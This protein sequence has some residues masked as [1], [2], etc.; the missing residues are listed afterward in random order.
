LF[1]A[2]CIALVT[3]AMAFSLRTDIMP[4]LGREFQLTDAMLGVAVGPGLWGFTLSIIFWGALLDVLGMR[5][6][7]WM[8]FAGHLIGTTLV[9]V[10]PG[11]WTLWTAWLVIG[12]SNGMVE[13]SINPL[14][15]TIYPD[16]KTQMLNILHAWWPGGLIIGGL[17][18]FGLSK[19]VQGASP[20]VIEAS[21]KIKMAF[22]YLPAV[23]YGVLLIGQK[24]PKTERVAA[25]VSTG[26]M[27][28]EV[29]RPMF[30]L[31]LFCMLLTASMELGP[32]QWI[33]V[34]A[35]KLI[36]GIPGILILVYTAGLMFV[37][38]NFAGVAVHRLKPL[39]LLIGSSIIAG[40]GLVALSCSTTFGVLLLAATVFGIGKTYFWPTMLGSVS[41]RFP[42][43][44]A[45]LLGLMGGAGML[46]VGSVT[47]PVMGKLQDR[48]L[49]A[50]L[51]PDVQAKVIENGRV[52]ET[53]MEAL[54]ET[55]RPA[56]ES[57]VEQAGKI[58]AAATLRWIAALGIVL[59]VIFGAIMINDMKRGGDQKEILTPTG[60]ETEEA[61]PSGET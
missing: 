14:A 39:G 4:D 27:F 8:A 29:F 10:A 19:L 32:D 16:K 34:L 22:V 3:T 54:P 48:Y 53:L 49:L 18:G 40:L 60:G 37:L 41:E 31:F 58:S 20:D 61:A 38:R 35:Q 42:K 46:V 45:L 7:L 26:D 24:F 33:N 28:K 9:I 51:P 30:L 5:T 57:A 21:W 43:G 1:A 15:A 25:G 2:S 6:A 56:I 59:V 50:E 12:L 36:K 47:V 11:M 44:G 55:E 13:A 52:S 17:M 23:I